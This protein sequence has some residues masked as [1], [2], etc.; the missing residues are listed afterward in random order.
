MGGAFSGTL[1][2]GGTVPGAVRCRKNAKRQHM[3]GNEP[4]GDCGSEANGMF[5]AGVGTGRMYAERKKAAY[6][7][8]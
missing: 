2:R 6:A 4:I 7:G 5:Y 8:K 1:P 3:P